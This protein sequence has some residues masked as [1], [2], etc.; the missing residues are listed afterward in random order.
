[1]V[2]RAATQRAALAVRVKAAPEVQAAQ[3]LAA[4]PPA[5]QRPAALEVQAAQRRAAQR[6]AEQAG[7]AALVVR[8]A[9]EPQ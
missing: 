5:V 6:L 2:R 1:M 9:A 3:R 7:W 8:A 4:Q